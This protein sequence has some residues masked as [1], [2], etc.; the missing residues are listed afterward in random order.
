[1][2][3]EPASL[4]TFLL[5]LEYLYLLRF[6]AVMVIR[7]RFDLTNFEGISG[8]VY[9]ECG[10]CNGDGTT[11]TCVENQYRSYSL[12][13]LD[14]ILVHY[15][16]EYTLDLIS[17]LN[18]TLDETLAALYENPNSPAINL[19]DAVEVIQQFN[20]QCLKTFVSDMDGFLSDLKT[21]A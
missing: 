5:P 17:T 3:K 6:L 15:N 8:H 20:D 19:G 21:A 13:E 7:I 14:R 2:N 10:I 16:I 12:V 4:L 18:S 1:V 11:C 9:D